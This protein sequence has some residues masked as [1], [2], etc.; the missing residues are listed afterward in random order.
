M[1]IFGM[2]IQELLLILLVCLL[3]FGANKLP[4]IGRSI[5]KAIQEFKKA[6]K[7]DKSNI[8]GDNTKP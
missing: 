7:E 1:R 8:E 4:E 6:I 2:G 5:G 3:F